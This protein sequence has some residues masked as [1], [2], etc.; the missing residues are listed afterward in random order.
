L[1][2]LDARRRE[3]GLSIKNLDDPDY[4]WPT[5]QASRLW[6]HAAEKSG[7][8]DIGL[9]SPHGKIVQQP[10]GGTLF[11]EAANLWT[12]LRRSGSMHANIVREADEE[13]CVGNS[14]DIGTGL[15]ANEAVTE[16]RARSCRQLRPD[17]AGIPAD[18]MFLASVVHAADVAL[19][20]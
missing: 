4:R 14:P 9:S 11:F 10:I 12:S 8:P 20:W 16:E 15:G 2:S 17:W 13:D 3:V 19:T 18:G 6:T 1:G 5:E 7:N